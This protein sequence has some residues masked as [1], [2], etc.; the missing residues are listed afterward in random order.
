MKAKWPHDRYLLVLAILFL[1]LW[2]ILAVSPHNRQDW[3]LENALVVP[4]VLALALTR[5]R[6]PFSRISYT[7]IFVFLCLHETGAHYTYAEVPYDAWFRALGGRTLNSLFGWE[8]NHFD[9]VAHFCFGLLWA[10]P[11]RE[12]FL[13][14]A[15]ARGLWGYYLPLDV[16]MALSMLFELIEWAAAEIFGGDLGVAYLGTQGDVWDAHKDMALASLGAILAMALTAALNARFQRDF[17]REWAESLRVKHRK[18]L[19][20]DEIERMMG[21]QR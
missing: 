3:A 10:Y 20:E 8:R 9:R 12:V 13:R 19:G 16:T 7:L 6:F 2:A 15:D 5:K 18:P 4:V 1:G 17:G 14:V 21:R 11:I